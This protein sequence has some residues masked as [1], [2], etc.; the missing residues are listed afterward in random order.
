MSG[1]L[2]GAEG[3]TT[4]EDQELITRIEKQLKRRF[5]IGS[6]VNADDHIFLIR[7][8]YLFNTQKP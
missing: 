3:F 7:R 5:A 4:Q 1:S 8:S 6:Q 2:S